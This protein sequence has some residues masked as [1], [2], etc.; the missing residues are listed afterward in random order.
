MGMRGGKWMEQAR[1]WRNKLGHRM[2]SCWN[3]KFIERIEF[4][5]AI[6]VNQANAI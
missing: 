5:T 6:S 2:Q 3:A 4:Q 1:I